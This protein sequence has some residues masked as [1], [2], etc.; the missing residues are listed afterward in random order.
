M[1]PPEY[2]GALAALDVTHPA[3]FQNF[4]RDTQMQDPDSLPEPV[5]LGTHDGVQY[6]LSSDYETIPQDERYEL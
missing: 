4:L 1:Q 3:D 5:P 6:F 2:L